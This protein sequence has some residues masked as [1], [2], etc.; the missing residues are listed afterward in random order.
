MQSNQVQLYDISETNIKFQ[1]NYESKLIDMFNRFQV[2]TI[3]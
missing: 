1:F 2:C 3:I